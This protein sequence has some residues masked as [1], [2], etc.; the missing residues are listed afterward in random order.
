LFASAHR[1]IQRGADVD[2]DLCPRIDI[3]PKRQRNLRGKW[4]MGGPVAI[5][6]TITMAVPLL[7]KIR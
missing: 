6:T 3:D 2:C 5:V 1:D 7:F 4:L